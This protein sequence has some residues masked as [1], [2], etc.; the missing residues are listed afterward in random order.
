[1]KQTLILLFILSSLFSSSQT[2]S[3][4]AGGGRSLGNFSEGIGTGPDA[5]FTNPEDLCSDA[6]GNFYVADTYNH[7]IRKFRLTVL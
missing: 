7:R 1:M 2:V 6:A 3:T 4:F 5:Q